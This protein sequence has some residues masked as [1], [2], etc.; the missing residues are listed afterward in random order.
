MAEADGE[1]HLRG[2]PLQRGQHAEV[3]VLPDETDDQAMLSLLR[4]D[5]SWSWIHDAAEDVYTDED[6][7]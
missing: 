5:P 7:H 6:A 3:I 2:L 1:L 4:E